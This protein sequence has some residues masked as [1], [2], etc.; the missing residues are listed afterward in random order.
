[1]QDEIL[2]TNNF[3]TL[4]SSGNWYSFDT[5][6]AI[7]SANTYA[8]IA[9]YISAALAI[10][11][12]DPRY[13]L[14]GSMVLVLIAVK[15]GDESA[16]KIPLN[17]QNTG[18]FAYRV[19]AIDRVHDLNLAS[20]RRAEREMLKSQ[21]MA[22]VREQNHRLAGHLGVPSGRGAEEFMF[23]GTRYPALGVNDKN[24]D[25][26]FFTGSAHAAQNGVTYTAPIPVNQI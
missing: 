22:N 2:F 12:K 14:A 15:Y 11:Y 4:F 18:T 6:S 19:T 5:S 23:G 8:R 26:S 24:R 7:K 16:S 21:V 17:D 3:G 10:Y 25:H 13:L 9:I 20:D 1:M